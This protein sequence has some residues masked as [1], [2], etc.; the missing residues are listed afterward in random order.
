MAERAFIKGNY[1]L[2]LAALRS[3][4]NFFAGYPITPA[5]EIPE[6]L[7]EKYQAD[8][9]RMA[10]GEEAEYPDFV[11]LQAESEIASRT[12]NVLQITVRCV[13]DLSAFQV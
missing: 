13:S 10:Q 11:F 1:A 4:L 7:A 8:R 5:S 2:A 9:M 6:Y 12:P 3:G